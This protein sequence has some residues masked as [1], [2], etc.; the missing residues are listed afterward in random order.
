MSSANWGGVPFNGTNEQTGGN[1][2]TTNLNQWYDSGDTGF[3]IVATAMCFLMV[4]GLGYFYSG[5]A[6]RK[7]ALSLIFICFLSYAVVSFQWYFW[8][9]SLAFSSTASNHFIGNLDNFAFMNVLAKPSVGSPFLSDL[10]FGIFQSQF[11][12]V[13]VAIWVGAAAERGRILPIIPISFIWMTLVYCPLAYWIWSPNGWAFQWGVLDFAGGGPVEIASGFSALAY[14]YILGPRRGIDLAGFR[15]HNVSYVVMGTALL[16]FGWFG[17][18]GGT[19]GGANLRA[20]MSFFNTNLSGCVGGIT[21]LLMDFRLERKWSCVSFASGM[22]SGLVAITPACGYI[23]PHAAVLTGVL[24]AAAGNLLT[25]LK[26]WLRSDDA[27]DI[28]SVHGI[29]GIVGLLI[30]GIFGVDYIIS[31]NGLNGGDPEFIITGGWL[32]GN[33]RQLGLQIA[34]ICAVSSYTFVV[35]FII[36]WV[37]D[38]I[39]GLQL[40]IPEDAENKGVDEWEIGEYAYDYVEIRRDHTTWNIPTKTLET[41]VHDS[42]NQHVGNRKDE[43]FSPSPSISSSS[44]NNNNNNN[45]PMMDQPQKFTI[46]GQETLPHLSEKEEGEQHLEGTIEKV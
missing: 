14:S 29:A 24:S 5:L 26:F 15:P 45:K 41:I 17:F 6:R 25:K 8:G 42:V 2:L 33:F 31:L 38:K 23:G 4:P 32:N 7:S 43:L 9:Y 28:L 1:S 22:V 10:L 34:Y 19:A 46:D 39:P 36:L 18:N 16:F 30:N 44:N 40:R 37:I 35:T 20:V 13:A 21:W 11:G 12:A 3:I 27:M